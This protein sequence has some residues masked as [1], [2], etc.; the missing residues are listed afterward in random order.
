MNIHIVY[1]IIALIAACACGFITI[2]VVL[3][4]CKKNGIYDIPNQR[5]IHKNAVPR[6]GGIVFLPSVLIGCLIAFLFARIEGTTTVTLS[7]WTIYFLFGVTAIYIIGIIDD[8]FDLN[9]VVKLVVQLIAASMLPLGALVGLYTVLNFNVS[10]P[11]SDK[12][13]PV[14]ELSSV[15]MVAPANGLAAICSAVIA[16][17]RHSVF[18]LPFL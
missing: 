12:A 5:K 1:S 7:L 6:L 8:L 18:Q 13:V 17:G 9:A 15:L 10:T 3:D 4:F 2:P 14:S 16:N 11:A